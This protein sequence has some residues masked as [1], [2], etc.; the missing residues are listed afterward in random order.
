MFKCSE[1]EAA[2]GKSGRVSCNLGS[3]FKNWLIS[4]V[5]FPVA[6]IVQALREREGESYWQRT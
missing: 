3:K 5:M 6:H 2:A 1:V 4:D